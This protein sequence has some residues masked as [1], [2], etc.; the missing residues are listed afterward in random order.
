[1][2]EALFHLAYML[3]LSIIFLIFSKSNKSH[4]IEE[5]PCTTIRLNTMYILV[6]LSNSQLM[7]MN[8]FYVL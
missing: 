5:I 6:P 8:K 2:M 3:L 4:E 7:A 1:M